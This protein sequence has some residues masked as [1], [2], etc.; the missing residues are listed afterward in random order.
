[1]KLRMRTKG[2]AE[3]LELPPFPLFPLKSGRLQ[4]IPNSFLSYRFKMKL[5]VEDALY[6]LEIN[7]KSLTADLG[8]G[9]CFIIGR[10]ALRCPRERGVAWRRS[11]MELRTVSPRK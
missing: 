2:Q 6:K 7:A 1:T 4:R 3:L 5:Q 10:R 8:Q 11:V 9:Y